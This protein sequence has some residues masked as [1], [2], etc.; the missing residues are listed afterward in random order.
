MYEIDNLYIAS[1][2]AALGE[3]LVT[4]T[5]NDDGRVL[6]IFADPDSKLAALTQDYYRGRFPAIQIADYVDQLILTRDKLSAAK[7][8]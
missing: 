3:Q 2:F 1:A 7:Q 4:T 8:R 5:K 6:F